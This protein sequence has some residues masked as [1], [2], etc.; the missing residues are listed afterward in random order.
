MARTI[1]KS[2]R[3]ISLVLAAVGVLA[4][5]AVGAA[6]ALTASSFKYSTAKTGYV[7][8]SP[9]DF[10]PDSDNA[11]YFNNWATGLADSS[12]GCHNAGVNLPQGSKV[13]SITF[14]YKS[15]VGSE[16]FGRFVRMRLGTGVGA[17][18]VTAVSPANDLGTASSVTSNVGAANQPVSASFA[19]GV[20]VCPGSD[21]TALGAR[22][23]YTYTSAGS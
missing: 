12:G 15:G 19:Y 6:Y 5:I 16:F 8:V 13:K 10:A 14:F 3:R 20:G 1:L 17:D 18:I 21:G 22:I 9:M 7:T 4:L 23:K 2:K 11:S